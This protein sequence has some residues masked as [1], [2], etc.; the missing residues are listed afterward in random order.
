MFRSAPEKHCFGRSHHSCS[1]SIEFAICYCYVNISNSRKKKQTTSQTTK[2]TKQKKKIYLFWKQ[3]Q[4][5]NLSLPLQRPPPQLTNP[6]LSFSFPLYLT[7]GMEAVC[8]MEDPHPLL[9][10]F[11]QITPETSSLDSY[12]EHQPSICWSVQSFSVGINRQVV[13]ESKRRE[14]TLKWTVPSILYTRLSTKMSFW[15]TQVY[16]SFTV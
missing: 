8:H 7:P 1:F 10:V 6:V 2:N 13:Q 12:N 4:T 5:K 15:D 14:D 16:C 3:N 9:W 11:C